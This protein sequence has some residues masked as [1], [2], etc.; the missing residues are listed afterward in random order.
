[1]RA[2]PPSLAGTVQERLIRVLPLAVAE[3]TVGTPGTVVAVVA[4][5]ALATLEA[6]PVPLVLMAE[7]R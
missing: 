4:V 5:V 1:M 7:T 2:E 3:R 6:S